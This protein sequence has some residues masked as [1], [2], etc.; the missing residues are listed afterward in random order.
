MKRGVA[1]HVF[2]TLSSIN[3]KYRDC[4]VAYAPAMTKKLYL[5]LQVQEKHR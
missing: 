3:C 1:A 5:F 4:R 2:K